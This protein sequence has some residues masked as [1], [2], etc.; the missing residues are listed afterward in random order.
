MFICGGGWGRERERYEGHGLLRFLDRGNHGIAVKS[1]Q[2]GA[3]VTFVVGIAIIKEV[4]KGLSRSMH[5]YRLKDGIPSS[6]D[7]QVP[8]PQRLIYLTA[9]LTFSISSQFALTSFPGWI[10]AIISSFVIK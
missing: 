7:L 3:D 4:L 9:S 1:S 5:D 6:P 2:A 8:R 10:L